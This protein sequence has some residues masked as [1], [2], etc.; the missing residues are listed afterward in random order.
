MLKDAAKTIAIIWGVLCSIV[1]T[2]LVIIASVFAFNHDATVAELVSKGMGEAEAASS[3]ES[4]TAIFFIFAFVALAAGVYSIILASFVNRTNIRKVSGIIL[5]S[6]AILL[7]VLVPGI[8]FIIDSV[9]TRPA[10]LGM[11]EVK[12]EEK[13]EDNSKEKEKK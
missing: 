11:N 6:F 10:I 9:K 3:T 2:I 4:V 1:A 5:G 12:E 8:L 13:K 7:G